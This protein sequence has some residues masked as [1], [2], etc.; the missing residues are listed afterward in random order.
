MPIRP[1]FT[2]AQDE[3]TVTFAIHVPYVRVGDAE[4]HVDGFDFSFWCKPFLLNL[5]MPHGIVDADGASAVYDPDQV[6]TAH[7]WR[8]CRRRHG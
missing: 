6:G 8:R 3:T 4:I 5:T 1:R 2:V 7:T